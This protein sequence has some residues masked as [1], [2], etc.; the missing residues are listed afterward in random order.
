MSPVI[1]FVLLLGLSFGVLW[2]FLR[3]SR[4]EAAVKRQLAS[5]ESGHEL[6]TDDTILKEGGLKANLMDALIGRLPGSLRLSNLIKQ[7]GKGWR[8]SHFVI[9]TMVVLL[10]GAWVAWLLTH[11]AGVSAGLGVALGLSPCA[12][13]LVARE[14]RFRRCDTLL[15]DAVDLMSRALRAGHA[16]PSCLEMVAN[17]ISEPLGSEFRILHD[18]H[19]LGLPLG[20][21]ILNLVSRIPR[22]DVRFLATALLV[23]AETGGNLTQILDK[24]AFVMRERLR[25]R[26]QVRIYTAQGRITGWILCAMPFVMFGLLSLVNPAYEKPL[27]DDPLGRGLVYIGIASM[28]VGIL[29]VNKIINVKV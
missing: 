4:T 6:R 28:I 15:P 13:L 22:D 2:Y 27:F 26:G 17:E 14:I 23:Q 5:I 18:E 11:N 16:V 1:V 20:D 8:A 12:Y 19:S 7:S 10:F 3:P 29:V 21:A 25:L 9:A 24:A